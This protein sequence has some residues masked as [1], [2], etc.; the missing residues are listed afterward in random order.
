MLTLVQSF[1]EKDKVYTDF[2]DGRMTWG[3]FNQSLKDIGEKTQV[4]GMR[5]ANQ[6]DANLQNQHAFEI[7]QRQRAAAAFQQWAYQQQVLANQR[8]AIAAANRPVTI[9]CNYAGATAQCTSF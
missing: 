5:A 8:A 6:I 7:E 3:Q 2:V 9:N 1:S 4:A